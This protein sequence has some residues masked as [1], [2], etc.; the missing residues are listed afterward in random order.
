MAP[1]DN[2]LPTTASDATELAKEAVPSVL[3][4]IENVTVP[5]GAVVPVAGFTVAVSVVLAVLPMLAG[6][7]L[8]VMAVPML[9]VKLDHCVTRLLASTE[10]SPVTSS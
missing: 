8:I 5:V 3:L 7:A 10:P 6:F 2:E 9:D 1:V 4:P